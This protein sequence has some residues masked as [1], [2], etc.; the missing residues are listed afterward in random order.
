MR[1]FALLGLFALAAP[2]AAA[3]PEQQMM[4]AANNVSEARL[5]ADI[6]KLVSFGTRHTMS[7]TVSDTRGIGAARRWIKSELERCGA[8]A[9]G[10][11][12]RAGSSRP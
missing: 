11:P 4:A 3:T 8:A 1:Q 10:R 5:R 2:A 6:V 12:A 9:G 7:D